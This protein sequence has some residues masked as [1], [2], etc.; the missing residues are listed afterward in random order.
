MEQLFVPQM[1]HAFSY[2]L[3][4]IFFLSLVYAV[5]SD[6][7]YCSLLCLYSVFK[8]E[9]FVIQFFREFYSSNPPH[10]P[11][12]AASISTA[13][14]LKLSSEFISLLPCLHLSLG[15]KLLRVGRC[16][17]TGKYF[18]LNKCMY[19][20]VTYKLKSILLLS[21]QLVELSQNDIHMLLPLTRYCQFPRSTLQPST[22]N[23]CS[24][25]VTSPSFSSPT[26]AKIVTILT[27]NAMK[28]FCLLY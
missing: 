13:F 22:H 1:G 9:I 25:Q 3:L 6:R 16:L 2:F 26:Y 11:P 5:C 23:F 24:L 19:S 8:S 14:V 15:W 4:C 17:F 21:V 18:F 7:T 28:W 20:S 12:Q 27:S 10:T